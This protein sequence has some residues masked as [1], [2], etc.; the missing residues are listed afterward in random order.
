MEI[1]AKKLKQKPQHIQV[2]V[3]GSIP[4]GEDFYVVDDAGRRVPFYVFVYTEDSYAVCHITPFNN[5]DTY[6]AGP[7]DVSGEILFPLERGWNPIQL[8]N[9]HIDSQQASGDVEFF[10]GY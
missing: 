9:I 6:P 1:L 5:D 2:S 8:K 7:D 10:Y 3:M 4:I